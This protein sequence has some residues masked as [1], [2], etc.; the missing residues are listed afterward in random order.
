MIR[1]FIGFILFMGVVDTVKGQQ[2]KLLTGRVA[3]EDLPVSSIHV[4]NKVRGNAVITDASGYFEISVKEG[5]IVVFSGVQFKPKEIVISDTI[6]NSDMITVHLETFVN[7]LDE[8]VVKPHNLSGSLSSDVAKTPSQINFDDVGIPGY[9]GVRREHIPSAKEMALSVLF[10]QVDV[11]AVYKHISGYYKR[12]KL[13]RKQ[14]YEFQTVVNI[15]QFYGLYFFKEN[16]SLGEDQVYD[17]VLGC[18]ENTALIKL[19]NQSQHNKVI[20]IFSDYS[21]EY[22]TLTVEN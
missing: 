3:H 17:F 11:E 21:K 14:S 15:I 12:L 16:Y 8:V 9:K 18:S 10:V 19:F 13:Q 1:V 2:F 7:E 4:I 20:Q 22:N 5:E 6:F